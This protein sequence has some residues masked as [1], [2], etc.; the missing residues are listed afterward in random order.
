[1]ILDDK[2]NE[3]FGGDD[4]KFVP[5]K[6]EVIREGTKGYIVASVKHCIVHWMQLSV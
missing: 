1:M 5:G 6:D 2:G 4:Y 3:F